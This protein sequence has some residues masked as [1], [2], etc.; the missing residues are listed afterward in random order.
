V[1][2]KRLGVAGGD[3]PA[4]L[5]ELP[6]VE[7]VDI[8]DLVSLTEVERLRWDHQG[9][10][11]SRRHPMTLLRRT[12]TMLEIRPIEICQRFYQSRLRPVSSPLIV[13][14]GGMVILRQMPP[15][16]NGYLFITLEDETGFIQCIVSPTLKEVYEDELRC[17]SLAVKG[18]VQIAG[19]WRGLV[20]QDVWSLDQRVIVDDLDLNV[21]D[22]DGGTNNTD[23]ED[24]RS[25]HVDTSDRRVRASR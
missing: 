17:P 14:I 13:V 23:V 22:S 19:N 12:L 8:P 3:R 21:I 4:T 20:V 9:Q 6:A 15:T 25:P 7:E 16:A 18:A 1:L 2:A 10:G 11:S 5:I 24:R